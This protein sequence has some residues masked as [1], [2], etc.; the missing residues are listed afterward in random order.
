MSALEEELYLQIKAL[1]IKEPKREHK[2]HKDRKWRFDFAWPEEKFA[3]E[4]EGGTCIYGRHNRPQGFENDCIKYG[5]AIRLGW[6]VYRC[7][8]SMVK[9]MDAVDFIDNFL[10]IKT[11]G[12]NE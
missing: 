9:K 7:T 1:K 5:E 2:F 12:R 11:G 6:D 10:K 8:S 3:V 4:V